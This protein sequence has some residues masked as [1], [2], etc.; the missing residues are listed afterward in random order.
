V[1]LEGLCLI[2][3]KV[4]K[5]SFSLHYIICSDCAVP[6]G[7]RGKSIK[8]TMSCA[9]FNQRSLGRA[10]ENRNN[11]LHNDRPSTEL[12]CD[13]TQECRQGDVNTK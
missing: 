4:N 8:K 9:Y 10:E 3:S 2:M 11:P 7:G 5:S 13:Q 6:E 1:Q 12:E